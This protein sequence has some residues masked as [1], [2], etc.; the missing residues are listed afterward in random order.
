VIPRAEQ[1]ETRI[2]FTHRALS[3]GALLLVFSMVVWGFRV[4]A[5]GSPVR[6]ALVGSA[7]FIVTEALVGASLVL[8]GW[9]ARD[10]S[11]ARAV[12]MSVHLANTFLLLGSLVLTVW[13]SGGAARP[14]MRSRG[15]L[16]WLLGLGLLGVLVVGM[17]G[18]ITA[19]GDTLFPA[20]SLSEG[21]SRDLDP[22]AHFLV[23]LRIY[24]PGLA[25]LVGLYIMGLALGLSEAGVDKATSRLRYLLI[26]AVLLQWCLGLLNV[27]LLVP[28]GTQLAHLLVADVVW[29][30][31]VL[32]SASML[33]AARPEQVYRPALGLAE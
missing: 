5:K 12:A 19:L 32:F 9:V 27:L 21:L 30:T 29:M 18:A 6:G 33:A 11:T 26:G 3:G 16:P 13:W 7:A 17:S 2:E 23:R 20:S 28:I 31:L 24:H 8:F 10:T 25:V 14:Q 1:E 15:L 4:H 22:G